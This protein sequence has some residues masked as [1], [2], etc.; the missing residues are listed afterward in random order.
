MDTV[1]ASQA[2]TAVSARLA[3]NALER[4]LL[5]LEAAS[6][7]DDRMDGR[8][9]DAMDFIARNLE[10]PLDVGTIAAAVNL[11]SSRLT[12][13]FTAQVGMPPSRYVEQ[14]RLER[15]RHLLT[16]TSMTIDA[17][18]RA[19]GFSSQFYFAA[20]FKADCGST[21]TAWRKRATPARR[22]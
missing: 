5:W 11:S 4:A 3:T 14:R 15:A 10:Q 22:A 2:T 18:A 1:V 8:L 12:H 7:G 6:P 19:T 21:A 20:R 13:L 9:H 16:S 17:I